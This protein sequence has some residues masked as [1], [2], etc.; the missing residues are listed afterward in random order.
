[1]LLTLGTM[2]GA[3]GTIDAVL[4]P[5]ALA[6]RQAVAVMAALALW[7]GTDGLTMCGGA[8]GIALQGLRGK[9]REE[10]AESRHGISACISALRCSY[11]SSCPLWVRGRACMVGSSWGW[12]R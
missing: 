8:G 1:M 3:T 2:P 12:P 5:T 6:R 10:I 11:A 4:C 9:S 7:D